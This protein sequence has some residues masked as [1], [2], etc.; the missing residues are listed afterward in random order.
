MIDETREDQVSANRNPNVVLFLSLYLLLLAFFILLN[1]ISNIEQKRSD[2]VMNSISSTFAIRNKVGSEAVPFAATHGDVLAVKEFQETIASMFDTRVSAARVD[3]LKPGR[4][5]RVIL[6]TD[7]IFV[8]D[9]LELQPE[10]APL[11][12]DL[13][14]ALNRRPAGLRFDVEIARAALLGQT[15]IRN[16][17]P[18]AGVIAGVDRSDDSV[19]KML[20]HV[21]PTVGEAVGSGAGSGSSP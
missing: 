15:L 12:S 11:F 2:S 1:A 4:L 16:G 14:R 13:G 18:D 9:R 8:A 21:R 10:L 19:I 20:F 6:P 17:V 5:M 3:V 7:A